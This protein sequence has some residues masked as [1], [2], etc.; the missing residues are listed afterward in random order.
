MTDVQIRIDF[1]NIL[2]LLNAT[3]AETEQTVAGV[4]EHLRSRIVLDLQERSPSS[5]ATTRYNP[6]RTVY[7]AAEGESPNPDTGNLAASVQ[8][9]SLSRF[10]Q[11]VYIGAEYGAALENNG[12]PFV[13][14]NVDAVGAEL[15]R[16]ADGIVQKLRSGR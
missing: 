13:I 15:P 10:E 8:R 9:E 6:K 2:Q 11:Q 4:A 5:G 1:N 16:L 3:E 7:P 14:P 12:H